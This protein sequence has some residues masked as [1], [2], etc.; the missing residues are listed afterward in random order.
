MIAQTQGIYWTLLYS[1]DIGC[2]P[3]TGSHGELFSIPMDL[4][5]YS[6]VG[7]KAVKLI[8]TENGGIGAYAYN[9]KTGQFELAMKYLDQVLF[10]KDDVESV[11][12]TEFELYIESLSQQE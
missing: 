8:R 1:V 2:Y 10:G 6:I 9:R 12:E 5:I 4:P 3:S 11:S 7:S